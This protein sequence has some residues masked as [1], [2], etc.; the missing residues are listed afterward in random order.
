[1]KRFGLSAIAISMLA[2]ML[3]SLGFGS[4][5]LYA[6]MTPVDKLLQNE[7]LINIQDNSY[8]YKDMQKHWASASIYKLSYMDILKGYPGGLMKPNQTLTREEYITMLVRALDLPLSTTATPYYSDLKSGRWSL[9]YINTAYENGLLDVYTKSSLEPEKIIYREEMAVIAA[10]AVKDVQA[11]KESRSFIDLTS[12]YKYMDSINLVTSLDIIR[13]MPDGS[14]KPYDS[15][16]RA[17]AAVI[18]LRLLSIK[19]EAASTEEAI[20]LRFVEN[21]E[22]SRISSEMQGTLDKN[23]IIEFSIGKEE[24]QNI[25]R[26]KLVNS[27][28]IQGIQLSRTVDQF[29]ADVTFLSKSLAEATVNYK[30]IST[31]TEEGIS[32]DYNVNR[33]IYLIKQNGSWVVYNSTGEHQATNVIGNG[34][35]I[36]LAWQYMSQRTPNMSNTAKIEG[37]NVISPTWFTLSSINGDFKS[38][39]DVSY[40]NWAH[41]NGYQV[42]A[43]VTNDF[44]RELST[45]VLNSSTARANAVNNLIQYAKNYKLDGINVD[46]ENMYAKDKDLFTQFVKELYAKT[47]P[48]GITLSVD[49]TVIVSN[50]TWSAC[51]DRKALAQVSDYIALMAYDQHWAGSPISG[52]VSQLK[53]VEDHVKK[54]LL[55]VP[56][57]KLLLGMPFYT[58]IWEE[59]LDASNNLVVSSRAV[60]M[61]Y[62]EKLVAENNASKTWDAVS[63][64]YFATYK[65]DGTTV[66][67]WLEDESSITLRVN[68][69]NKYGLAGVASWKLGFEKQGIWEAIASALNKQTAAR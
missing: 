35:K 58:R 36:N 60:S 18:I 2:V 41:E 50:S 13:G 40:T 30:L 6:D 53:W 38:I 61:E 43:L 47:K 12:D 26:N 22:K 19:E 49:V 45:K 8:T 11:V 27:F 9:R 1:M 16:N 57:E 24:K 66:K 44:D 34:E 52:S 33:T 20:V 7:T 68:L 31:A 48:L 28:I 56:K 69:A 4:T 67:I 25:Q 21:Y 62:A 17:E 42:W 23:G 5:E 46:F 55:E 32:R 59:K 15:A 63:G 64:Q 3:I 10:R 37:L 65:K 39:A 54:V 51:Y 14:F 29:T